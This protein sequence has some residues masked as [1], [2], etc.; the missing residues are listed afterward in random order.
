MYKLLRSTLLIAPVMIASSALAQTDALRGTW[1]GSW[2]PESGGR[3]RV[4][5]RFSIDHDEIVG[6]LVNPEELRF[7][8][9]SFD[10]RR[11]E[12]EAEG[13]SESM[14]EISMEARIEEETRL[15]GELTVGN[16]SGQIHLTKWTFVPRAR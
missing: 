5:V 9:V 13:S 1:S 7:D 12:L 8:E 4:T 10:S 6:E 11:L 15:N 14:G 2:T 3:E 16:K